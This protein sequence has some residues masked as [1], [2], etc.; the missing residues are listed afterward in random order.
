MMSG[1]LISMIINKRPMR[2]GILICILFGII[3]NT[4]YGF[5]ENGWMILAGRALC[6]VSGNIGIIQNT[7][8]GKVVEEKKR[9]PIFSIL[10]SVSG[11]G[12]LTGPAL[13]LGLSQIDFTIKGFNIN[14]NNVPG[15]FN[16][17]NFHISI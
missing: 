10:G 11:F 2:E 14:P 17:I 6:G 1:F 13:N 7:Y 4:I 12:I 3:G 16:P 8:I 5:A 15:N 9:S